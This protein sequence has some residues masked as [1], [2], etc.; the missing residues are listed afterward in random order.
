MNLS[1]RIHKTFHCPPQTFL[2]HHATIV[3][4]SN[5]TRNRKLSITQT[6][7]LIPTVLSNPP[8]PSKM[9]FTKLF[10]LAAFFAGAAIAA[11]HAEPN[12]KPTKPPKPSPK[13]PTQTNACNNDA[14]A[15][16]CN[17]DGKGA[18]SSCYPYRKTLPIASLRDLIFHPLRY[19]NANFCLNRVHQS[20]LP[21]RCLLQQ[22]PGNPELYRW[23]RGHHGTMRDTMSAH[24]ATACQASCVAGF[25]QGPWAQGLE[26]VERGDSLGGGKPVSVGHFLCGCRVI[27]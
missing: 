12:D 14:Q 20:M 26:Q 9:Q 21:D 3:L 25:G 24:T 1:R 18:Y 6:S 19:A 10:V 13:P 17:S 4:T 11:P 5:P 23:C 15:Y 27:G 2:P 7:A 8:K 22:Q 16:C